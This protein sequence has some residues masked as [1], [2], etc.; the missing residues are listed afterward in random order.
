M[1][2]SERQK[3][4]GGL[5]S[6]LFLIFLLLVVLL[7]FL[8]FLLSSLQLPPTS[9]SSISLNLSLIIFGVVVLFIAIFLISGIHVVN[10]WKGFQF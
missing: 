6:S 2:S 9:F 5:F 8:P 4:F 7:P 3:N 10:E 1:N